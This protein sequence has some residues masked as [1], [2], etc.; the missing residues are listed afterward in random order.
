MKPGE[1]HRYIGS[2]SVD[3]YNC[4]FERNVLETLFDG[5]LTRLP[6]IRD[7]DAE[8]PGIKLHLDIQEQKQVLRM[9]KRMVYD[10]QQNTAGRE[11]KLKSELASLLVDYARAYERFHTE[12][13]ASDVYPNY[14]VSALELISDMYRDTELSVASIADKVG[15]TPD[16]LSKQF[17]SL[18]GVG[19]QEYIRRFRFSKATELLLGGV[20]VSDTCREVG[21]TNLAHFSREF[22]KVLGV[23]PTQYAKLN[24]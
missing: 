15:V 19:A 14:V 18:T 6:G 22:K 21:F 8:R 11:I 12:H 13:S 4:L 24:A 2:H 1:W 5:E 10:L 17:R 20:R 9:L 3:L 16:Y 23:S 7:G